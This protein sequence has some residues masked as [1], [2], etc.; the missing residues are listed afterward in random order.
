VAATAATALRVALF[1]AYRPVG[2]T[3]GVDLL[4][5]QGNALSLTGT[6]VLVA[7]LGTAIENTRF[8]LDT[9]LVNA[10]L[11]AHPAGI[12]TATLMGQTTDHTT[13]GIGLRAYLRSLRGGGGKCADNGKYQG[14][15]RH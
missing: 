4:L 1:E 3:F 8:G 12:K 5:G 13:F 9:D 2:Q 6:G 14:R 10:L 15:N 11:L 7:T